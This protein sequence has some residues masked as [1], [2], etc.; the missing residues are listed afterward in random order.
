MR[1]H[2]IKLI[3]ALAF[4]FFLIAV[5][6]AYPEQVF[7]KNGKIHSGKIIRDTPTQM[8]LRGDDGV[9][10]NI[11]RAD[12]MRV[13]YT[14]IY[15][16]KQ[17]I[18][19]T[20]GKVLEAY[21]VD[22]DQDTITVRTVLD[23][24][25]EISI[26]RSRVLFLARNNPTELQA[27]P[28]KTS[29]ALKWQ[30]PYRKPA[31]YN[32]YLRP[33]GAK[34]FRIAGTTK[35]T[36]HTIAGLANRTDYAVKVTAVDAEGV[37]SLPSNEIVTVTTVPPD[38]PKIKK[39]VERLVKGGTEMEVDLSW[40]PARDPDGKVVKYR[41]YE[42]REVELRRSG[43]TG[44]LG[45]TVRGLD[46]SKKHEF[47]VRSVDDSGTESV[48][49]FYSRKRLLSF[50]IYGHYAMPIES[51]GNKLKPFLS[52][53]SLLECELYANM[54]FSLNIIAGAGFLNQRGDIIDSR[55]LYSL[56]LGMAGITASPMT[57]TS[58]E[59]K[60][61]NYTVW[62]T[63]AGPGFS[64]HPTSFFT[65]GIKFLAGYS[66]T[67]LIRKV[68][69]STEHFSNDPAV[70]TM[71]DFRFR[72][73]RGLF[74]SLQASYLRVFYRGNDLSEGQFGGGIGY[75]FGL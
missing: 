70:M 53:T 21:L 28:E 68:I 27:R 42:V 45:L 15:P 3:S 24:P 38:F 73:Y 5:D 50:G 8:V 13:L 69:I 43:E 59:V 29:I 25:E 9:T 34:D 57:K 16:G 62:S 1:Y 49:Q 12:I 2:G 17:Y 52:F 4:I 6:R 65:I 7:I 10:V 61:L 26:P 51:A 20:D 37:E 39:R 44:D 32:V 23:K 74:L 47:I 72:M 11:P 31:F 54:P 56:L 63:W 36:N 60:Q 64:L 55:V 48:N 33:K 18:R 14:K 22:E 41:V 75:A 67:E 30:A 35:K 19:L 58:N 40:T 66:R 46:P 71:I